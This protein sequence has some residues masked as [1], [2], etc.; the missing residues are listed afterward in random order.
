MKRVLT[1]L[2][3]SIAGSLIIESFASG[4]AMNK[5]RVLSK[6]I[7]KLTE[8]DVKNFKPDMIFGYDYSFLTDENCKKVVENSDCK[9]FVFYFADEPQSKFAYGEN[10]K[11]YDEL[12]ALDANNEAN[13]FI[14]DKDF[15]ADFKNS[16]Y[17]PL[18]A[19][20]LK[21]AIDFDGYRYAI[22]FVGRPLT[23]YRQKILCDLIKVFKNKVSIF[24]FEKHFEQS[25]EEIKAQN[26]LSECDLEIYS[27]C[28]RGFIKTE[29]ELAVI[30][31]SSKINLNITEQGKSSLNYRVFE[32]LAAGGFLLTDERKDIHRYFVSSKQL[33]IYKDSFDLIDKIE[34]Y[35]NNL[36]IAQRIAQLGRFTCIEKHNFSAR[37]KTILMQ[38]P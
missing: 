22:T 28:W 37:A 9:N 11:L 12:K 16:F 34:F 25:I 29:E 23:P 36:N 26:L 13:I 6:E 10:K 3:K 33:E 35:L 24:C 20:P 27:K 5:C 8:E 38:I 1:L 32:V 19:S 17:L 30:Y 31:N 18:A 14:W 15:L 4:F 21:Y 7:D 2:P